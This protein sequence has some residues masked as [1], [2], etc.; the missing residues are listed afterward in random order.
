MR[1]WGGVVPSNNVQR[2]RESLMMSKAELARKA[3]L[4]TLTIDR[5]EAGRACRLDTKRKILLALGMKISEKGQLFG[6]T[7]GQ[8]T[9]DA[10]NESTAGNTAQAI[11]STVAG[12]GEHHGQS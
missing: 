1:D 12:R 5:V 3:G 8:S 11:Q 7:A 4:S 2:I 9:L 6:E 10:R